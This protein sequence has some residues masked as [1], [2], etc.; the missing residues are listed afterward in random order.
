MAGGWSRGFGPHENAD[1]GI[2]CTGLIALAY[3]GKES[4]QRVRNARQYLQT[5]IAT[6]LYP[7]DYHSLFAL[8]RTCIVYGWGK[9][10]WWDWQAWGNERLVKEQKADGSW[11]HGQGTAMDTALALFF[12]RRAF[13]LH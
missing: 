5:C 2:T 13:A 10:E 9:D 1:P 6:S 11:N 7:N 3:S 8:E 12:M 4:D